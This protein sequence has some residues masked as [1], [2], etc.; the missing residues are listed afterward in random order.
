MDCK[1]WSE[2]S[3]PN[4]HLQCHLTENK[5]LTKTHRPTVTIANNNGPNGTILQVLYPVNLSLNSSSFSRKTAPSNITG[6][7]LA[8][9]N[10]LFPGWRRGIEGLYPQNSQWY[11]LDTHPIP[12]LHLPMVPPFSRNEAG[13]KQR[14]KRAPCGSINTSGVSKP[15]P[16]QRNLQKVQAEM[17]LFSLKFLSGSKITTPKIDLGFL[18]FSS[19]TSIYPIYRWCLTPTQLRTCSE[20]GHPGCEHV[21]AE[22]S[23]GKYRHDSADK[24]KLSY[25]NI[26]T[27]ARGTSRNTSSKKLQQQQILANKY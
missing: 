20:N 25:I 21:V 22:N 4:R 10:P 16:Q 27:R 11:L 26:L 5:A 23:P 24:V 13:R 15:K 17:I 2:K 19:M 12:I 3:S 9:L 18:H 14:T 6:E 8:V 1:G 7:T